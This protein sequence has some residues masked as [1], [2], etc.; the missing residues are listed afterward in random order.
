MEKYILFILLL[1]TVSCNTK[2]ENKVNLDT[3]DMN[4]ID[5]N[6][7]DKWTFLKVDDLI[8]AIESSENIESKYI[9]F[10]GRKSYIY[11][12]YEKLLE[13]ASD[14]LWVKLSYSK[15][16]V[17][18]Y[19][20]CMALLSNKSA[21]FISVKN[22]LLKDTTEVCYHAMDVTICITLGERIEMRCK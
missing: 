22:R 14:S 8:S 15:S 9:G 13:V 2:Q 7:I 16:P 10:E 1:F 4:E 11:S 6:S 19:Y 21:N 12:C 17:M 3:I 20:A 18:R 5:S